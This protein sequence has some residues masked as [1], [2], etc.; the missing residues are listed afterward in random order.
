MWCGVCVGESRARVR[1]ERVVGGCFGGVCVRGVCSCARVSVW[2]VC[3]CAP[4]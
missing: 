1:G 4:T 3:V 2:C